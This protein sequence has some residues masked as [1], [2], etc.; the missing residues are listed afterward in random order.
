MFD[1][2]EKTQNALDRLASS[3]FF[4][5]V[6]GPQRET[7]YYGD[8][9]VIGR[10]TPINKGVYLGSNAREAIVV[11][12]EKYPKELNEAYQA[13]L[14]KAAAPGANLFEATADIV[15]DRL[16]GSQGQVVIQAVHKIYD[17]LDKSET[18]DPKIRLNV[19]IQRKAGYCTQ[20]SLLAGYILERAI[21]EGKIHG[22]VSVDRKDN[23]VEGHAWVRFTPES[24]GEPTI[25]DA[26]LGYVGP[27]SRAPGRWDYRRPG[28]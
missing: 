15:R 28:E 8:R 7:G 6:T 18:A 26:T 10:D 19:Y 1:H 9:H 5:K 22:K 16:G 17:E 4:Y 12:D 14:Q 20:R 11:D 27:L 23:G 13:V 24:G 25:V 2:W 3:P 21:K